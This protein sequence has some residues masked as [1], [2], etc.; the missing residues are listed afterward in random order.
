MFNTFFLNQSFSN[1]LLKNFII[2]CG[3]LMSFFNSLIK[4]LFLNFLNIC[5]SHKGVFSFSN[6]LVLEEKLT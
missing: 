4:I 1:N 3:F 6:S 5:F 2:Y